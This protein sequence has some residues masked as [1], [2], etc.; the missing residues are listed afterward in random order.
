[1]AS[2][3]D[4]SKSSK[5]KLPFS[6]LSVQT[7][8]TSNYQHARKRKNRRSRLV[9]DEDELEEEDGWK[10]TPAMKEAMRKSEKMRAELTDK[11]LQ[12]IIHSIVHS[13]GGWRGRNAALTQVK[14]QCPSFSQFIDVVLLTT[15]I[16]SRRDNEDIHNTFVGKDTDGFGEAI[17]AFIGN[18]HD[19]VLNPIVKKRKTVQQLQQIII[20]NKSSNDSEESDENNS[21]QSDSEDSSEGS[22]A[23]LVEC[24]S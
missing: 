22:K 19:F 23:S 7:C 8:T 17:S 4:S 24:S 12:T 6:L 1:M 16:I 20:Q 15:G 11:G 9:E 3:S 10:I 13:E 18:N 14:S 5:Y 2:T 21:D